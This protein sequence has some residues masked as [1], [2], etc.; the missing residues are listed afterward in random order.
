VRI[1][2]LIT[3]CLKI[4]YNT[5]GNVSEVSIMMGGV[6][7]WFMVQMEIFCSDVIMKFV[8]NGRKAIKNLGE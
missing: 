5:Q 6:Q 8:N 2:Q 7:E 1:N 4:L 3:I